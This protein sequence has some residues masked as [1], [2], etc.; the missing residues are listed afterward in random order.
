MLKNGWVRHCCLR[1]SHFWKSPS[2]HLISLVRCGLSTLTVSDLIEI[3]VNMHP[4]NQRRVSEFLINKFKTSD[5]P[6]PMWR[7]MQA[8]TKWKDLVYLRIHA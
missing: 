1:C 2:W 7:L 8:V 6:T 5:V 3:L 4:E